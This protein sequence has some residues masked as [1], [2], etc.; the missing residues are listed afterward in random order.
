MGFQNSQRGDIL[1]RKASGAEELFSIDKFRRSLQSA[2]ACQESID[3]IV[4]DISQ[5]V[6]P[7]TST[8]KIYAR[9]FSLLHKEKSSSSLRYRLKQAILEIGP[10]GYPFEIL[11][12]Q[13]FEHLGYEVQTGITVDGLHVTHE[14]DVIAT[15][16]KAQQLVECKYHKDQG[17]QV[18]VQVPLYVRS[19]VNDIVAKRSPLPE[20]QGFTFTGW[21]ITNTRFSEDSIQ[22]GTGAGL[23]LLAWDFPQGNGLKEHLEKFRL[24]PI[25]ILKNLTQVKRQ[26]LLDAGIVTCSQLARNE[27]QIA[28]LGLSK[29][30]LKALM[31]E[32]KH[33]E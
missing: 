9:A 13:L 7:G 33:L 27:A 30:K 32:L 6:Q 25:T 3:I 20:Y 15:A 17:K 1:I 26:E 2:G 4:N 5:W 24:Y 14:M 11:M 18:S 12:G 21:V 10:T 16:N 22:Y 31:E 23:T 29:N 8:K 28:N 19:R